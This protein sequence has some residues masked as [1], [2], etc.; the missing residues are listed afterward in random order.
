MDKKEFADPGREYRG[1]TLWMLNDLLSE[2]EIERQV[3]SFAKAG[4]GALITRTFNGL[5]TEY[6]SES[7]HKIVERII[8]IAGKRSMKVW[9]QAGHMPSA[10]PQLPAHEQHQVL[11][12]K[13]S[14]AV[15]DAAEYLLAELISNMIGIRIEGDYL[16]LRVAKGSSQGTADFNL[17]LEE[18]VNKSVSGLIRSGPAVMGDSPNIYQENSEA[19]HPISEEA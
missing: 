11:V 15:A 12:E 17:P 7:W 18:W 3:E 1:V 8:D 19:I 4:W 13:T 6:L 9:L 10:V 2:E 14:P 16:S 5:R